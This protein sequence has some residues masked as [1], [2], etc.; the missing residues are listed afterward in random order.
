MIFQ[1]WHLNNERLRGLRD[2]YP[3]ISETERQAVEHFFA[4]KNPDSD[5]DSRHQAIQAARALMAAGDYA[6]AAEVEVDGLDV[7]ES[8]EAVFD[9]TRPAAD[10]WRDHPGVT[11][12]APRVR[13]TRAGDIIVEAEGCA[14]LAEGIGFTRIGCGVVA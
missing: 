7:G 12:R 3:S 5:E 10:A 13:S 4:V 9:R 14:W 1:V 11:V 8:L 2:T 6:L